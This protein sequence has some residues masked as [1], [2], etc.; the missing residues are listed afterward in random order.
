MV[1]KMYQ[2]GAVLTIA[3]RF[4]G[5]HHFDRAEDYE[6]VHDGNH[7]KREIKQCVEEAPANR[8]VES[9][10]KPVGTYQFSLSSDG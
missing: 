1:N 7:L 8:K 2:I 6:E 3:L 4:T 9:D 5:G 10:A